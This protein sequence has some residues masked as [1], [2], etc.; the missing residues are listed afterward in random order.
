MKII[1][2]FALN[3][4]PC[5]FRQFDTKSKQTNKQTNRQKKGDNKKKTTSTSNAISIVPEFTF[6]FISFSIH[7]SILPTP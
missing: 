1:K 4:P 2:M 3:N 6:T 7:L 5:I